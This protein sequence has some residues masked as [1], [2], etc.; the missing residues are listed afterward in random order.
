[1]KTN[2]IPIYL[3]TGILESGK[4]TFIKKKMK[5][6]HFNN[7]EKTLIIVC[8]TGIEEYNQNDPSM[9]NS[10]IFFIDDQSDINKDFL[11]NIKNDSIERVLIEYNGMWQLDKLYNSLP[12][13]WLIFQQFMFIDVSTFKSY[14]MM[15]RNQLAKMF[16]DCEICV[17]NRLLN[18]NEKE[19]LHKNAR[20][21]SLKSE[22]YYEYINHKIEKDNIKDILPFDLTSDC[23][24]IKLKDYAVWY[25][26]ITTDFEKYKGREIQIEGQIRRDI[27]TN[28]LFFGRKVMVC[29]EADIK[30][31]GMKLVFAGDNP[32]EVN[33]WYKI[34]GILGKGDGETP[35]TLYMNKHEIIDK[36]NINEEVATF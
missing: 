4:T 11:N 32:L 28:I 26:D 2:T 18:E 36:P 30:F 23:I 19:I 5:D 8:E 33:K 20:M 17:F 7:G 12:N 25:L 13:N 34:K 10:T 16:Q 1:M 15:F 14:N 9:E 22:I 35:I 31:L 27:S 6:T 24:K 29:C 3:F 21:F